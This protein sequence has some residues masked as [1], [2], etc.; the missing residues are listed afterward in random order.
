M[1]NNNSGHV[2]AAILGSLIAGIFLLLGILLTHYLS[3]PQ[4]TNQ[5]T[6]QQSNSS[7]NQ[8]IA[9]TTT[10][11]TENC[12][13]AQGQRGTDHPADGTDWTISSLNGGAIVVNFYF[14]NTQFSGNNKVLVPEG[15]KSITFKGGGGSYWRYLMGCATNAQQDF[16][17]L[18]HYAAVN[19]Q[20]LENQGLVTVI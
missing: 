17:T 6:Y 9:V 8:P 16:D 12:P 2:M 19:L 5:V 4:V 20:V 14:P 18:D 3:T 15:T 10:Q 1:H 7:Q 13:N 11:T